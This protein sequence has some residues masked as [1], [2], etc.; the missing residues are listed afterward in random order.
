MQQY[1]QH[2]LWIYRTQGGIK[3]NLLDE[4]RFAEALRAPGHHVCEVDSPTQRITFNVGFPNEWEE[5]QAHYLVD[6]QIKFWPVFN[7]GETLEW[8]EG[9]IGGPEGIKQHR[10]TDY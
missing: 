9:G 2:Y 1:E 5:M 6:T 3:C 8:T 7:N 10:L 4:D